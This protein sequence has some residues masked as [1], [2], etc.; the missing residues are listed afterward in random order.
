MATAGRTHDI[1]F[2]HTDG[3]SNEVGLNVYRESPS[4]IGGYLSEIIP[5][6]PDVRDS[7]A[8]NQSSYDDVS[9]NLDLVFEQTSWHRGLGQ[10]TVKRRGI[11]DH[12]YASA[13]GV[14]TLFEGALV[15]GWYEDHVDILVQNPR[16]EDSDTGAARGWT[17]SNTTLSTDTT[18][19]RSGTQ[20]LGVSVGSNNGTVTQ[21][22]GG[23][24]ALFR[25]ES[26]TLRFYIKRLTGSG[27]VRCNLIDSAGGTTN[28]STS[29]SEDYAQIEVTATINGSCSAIDFQLE[30]SNSGSTWVIDDCSLLPPGDTVDFNDD[31]VTLSDEKYLP[32]GR[33]VLKWNETDD[34]FYAVYVDSA[35]DVECI[36]EFDVSGS[37]PTLFIGFAG[38]QIYKVSTNGTTWAN[39]T[40]AST[41]EDNAS[42]FA[43][44]RDANGNASLA[45]GYLTEIRLSGGDVSSAASNFGAAIAVASS[46]KPMTNLFGAND[47]LYVGK[48]DGLYRYDKATAKFVDLEPEGAAFDHPT[49]YNAAIGRGGQIYAATGARSFFA[50]TDQ[51]SRVIWD[52]LSHLVKNQTW[53]GFSGDVEAITQDKANIWLSLN[54]ALSQNFPY[55]FPL[56][57][58]ENISALASTRILVL[59]PD[60]DQT[61]GAQAASN[62]VAHNIT[63]ISA[64]NVQRMSR[65]VQAGNVDS[66][67][68]MGKF[69]N[70]D[71]DDDEARIVRIRIPTDNEN[72]A[73]ATA[74]QR[75]VRKTAFFTSQH[76]DWF[77]PD[78]PKTLTKITL[79]TKNL[80][81]NQTI[82]V[83]YKKDDD[84]PEDGEG[85]TDIASATTSPVD[86]VTT[87][88]TT[89]VTFRRIR[90]RLKL[91]T[92]D[93]SEAIEVFSYTIHAVFNP[94][95]HKKW[96]VETKLSDNRNSRRGRRVRRRSTLSGTDLTNL[97]TLRQ[98]PFCIYEDQDGTTYR[99][100]I[101]QIKTQWVES[102]EMSGGAAPRKT[103]IIRLELNEVRTS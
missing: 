25:G 17:A 96:T 4:L 103:K 60:V 42:F 73:R 101:R 15:S 50:V 12:R 93:I 56:N 1:V 92:D 68:A 61:I 32:C 55:V 47:L 30:F 53:E 33:M 9:P 70:A 80:S 23:N 54:S 94:I 65:F 21:R 5:Y 16:F 83:S 97:E 26:I 49:N 64:T 81:A 45:K 2:R 69:T 86:T 66:M 46:D 76:I 37:A 78:I 51:D 10:A 43:V 38:N 14:L 24:A 99:A 7:F 19:H 39:P 95:E 11:D 77:Y 59:R 72:P 98:E 18:N 58:D 28:G 89:P 71:S 84:G 67:F 36:A 20:C 22:Y 85:W 40:A 79:V 3:S 44:T 31:P 29:S 27:T 82:L 41:T 35:Y 75:A 91:I 63:T 88:L 87:S 34:A 48:T 100:K 13:D 8:G 52:D 6:A 57:F 62:L 90:I 102:D 74:T